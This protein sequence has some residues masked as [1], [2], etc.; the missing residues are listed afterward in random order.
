MEV[1]RDIPDAPLETRDRLVLETMQT[2]YREL[3]RR[4][5]WYP[6]YGLAQIDGCRERQLQ[7]W[8][9]LVNSVRWEVESATLFNDEIPRSDWPDVPACLALGLQAFLE[10]KIPKEP[11]PPLLVE[12]W[13]L[14]C[15]FLTMGLIQERQQLMEGYL[16]DFIKR[17]KA[18]NRIGP[19]FHPEHVV[20][21][22]AA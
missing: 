15:S 17:H 3:K 7:E 8:M 18:D 16:E 9:I 14:V 13:K 21:T 20:R 5:Y 19:A 22:G 6:G 2:V 12:T 10:R 11:P 1:E 4:P